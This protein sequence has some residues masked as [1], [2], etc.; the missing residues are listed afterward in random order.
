VKLRSAVRWLVHFLFWGLVRARVCW[1]VGWHFLHY[2]LLPWLAW[3]FGW[4]RN[5]RQAV[6]VWPE[7][8]A[9][10]GPRVALFCHFDAQGAVRSDVLRYLTALHDAGYSVVVV[11]NSGALQ[12]A[13]MAALQTVCAAVLVRRNIG[14]DFCA[15]REGLE[16]FSLPRD[17]TEALL[18]ANDSVYG[19]LQPLAPLLSRL[20]AGDAD[21]WGLTDSDQIRFHLQSYFLAVSATAMR[22]EAWRRFWHGVRPYPSKHLMIR[23]YEIGLTQSLARA[24]LRCRAMW[25]TT[26]MT[27]PNR[28][29]NTVN[30]TH[31]LWRQ[32]LNAGFP[33][34]KRE[35]VRD[36]P[37]RIADAAEW[38]KVVAGMDG[39]R[40]AEIE[41][42]LVRVR[43]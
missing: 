31:D 12:P 32:L 4:L 10:L 13:A 3:P 24:G 23:C 28:A 11:S 41:Q 39:A 2:R 15:W 40:L 35:L 6:V 19:P 33:F 42:D 27:L 43:P 29:R 7:H 20:S 18:L 34:I 17:N 30:P 16:L 1:Q 5:P 8:S 22:S 25:P 36:N 38:R 9:A 21:V 14:L 37:A 26:A